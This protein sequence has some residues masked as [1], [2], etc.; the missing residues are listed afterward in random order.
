MVANSI[1]PVVNPAKAA[2]PSNDSTQPATSQCPGLGLRALIRA[3]VGG[4]TMRPPYHSA[5]I[6]PTA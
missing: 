6:A 5:S 4:A 2:K 3:Q 1:T